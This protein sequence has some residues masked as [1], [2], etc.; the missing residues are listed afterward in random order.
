MFNNSATIFVAF[1]LRRKQERSFI[2]LNCSQAFDSFKGSIEESFFV[3]GLGGGI[4]V[5]AIYAWGLILFMAT[6]FG[7]QLPSVHS[8]CTGRL[9]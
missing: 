2:A 5:V 8:E 9:T 6:V 1:D 4:V 3:S 7:V